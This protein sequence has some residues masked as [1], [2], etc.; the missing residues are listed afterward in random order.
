PGAPSG[1]PG[2]GGPGGGGSPGGGGDGGGGG[3]GAPAAQPAAG[4]AAQ[5][6]SNSA[7]PAPGQQD[8]AP[9][10]AA[11]VAG[12]SAHGAVAIRAGRKGWFSVHALVG[13]T[14]ATVVY[15][16]L[17]ARLRFKATS[18]TAL[19]VDRTRGTA[20]LRGSGIN[21]NT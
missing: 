10:A 20:T 13:G 6:A 5:P 7:A 12:L 15:T 1:S 9:K 4:P 11:A 19:A 8:A 16:D 18:V 17:R 21:L 3:G 2:G 14:A